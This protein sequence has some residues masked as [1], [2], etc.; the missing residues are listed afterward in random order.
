M[1]A[2][3]RIYHVIYMAAWDMTFKRYN[4]NRTKTTNDDNNNI[5]IF[6]GT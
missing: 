6:A 5:K 3:H 4:I 1:A 2:R